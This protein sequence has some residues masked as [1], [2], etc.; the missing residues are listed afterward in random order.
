MPGDMMK[1]MAFSEHG[2]S[3]VLRMMT[4]D[5]PVPHSG[6]ALVRVEA[7][8]VNRL[9][10]AVRRGF[11]GL[12]LDMPHI[13]GAD[14]AGRIAAVAG[15]EG[16]FSEGDR[17]VFNPGI[18]CGTCLQCISGR[19]SL[20]RDYRI[21]GEHISG[22]YAQFV[23]VPL[24]NLKRVPDDYPSVR[25]AAAPL[26]YLTAWHAL[27][28]RAGMRFG[29]RLLITGGSGGVSTAAIQI[30]KLFNCHVGVTT[31]N[32]AKE[33]ALLTAG[34]DEVIV[35]GGG[36]GWAREYMARGGKLFDIVLDS[37]GTALWKDSFRLLEK[38]GR[39]VNYGR[40]SGGQI[41]TDL[42][43]VFWKQLGIL[44]STMGDPGEF[45]TVM[46]LVFS[47][48]LNPIVDRVFTLEEAPQAHDYMESGS[49]IGKIVLTV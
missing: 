39:F 49:H 37:V 46:D 36:E 32:A 18:S 1:G 16:D 17:V 25:A 13:P 24:R 12:R 5:V 14:A 35:T 19:A 47:G 20:C 41:S 48:R 38:G 23:T 4:F 43:F 30:G 40:T 15:G 8:S 3:D 44:G 6:E 31:R 11:P 2:T 29:E 26:V 27:A 9:D 22:T 10:I 45:H 33:E 21:L 28:G 7:A 34:A 42:S